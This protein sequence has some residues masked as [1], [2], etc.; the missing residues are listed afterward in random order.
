MIKMIKIGAKHLSEFPDE[1]LD[2]RIEQLRFLL[3]AFRKVLPD[4]IIS[5]YELIVSSA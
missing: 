5:E 4:Q 1:K 2:L 3:T